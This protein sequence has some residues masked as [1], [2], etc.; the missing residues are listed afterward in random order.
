MSHTYSN[1]RSHI[2]FSTKDRQPLIDD[3]LKPR[4][5]GYINGI[6]SGTGGRVLSMN[7]M[8]DHLHYSGTCRQHFHSQML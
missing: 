6:A 1:L 2:V 7:A 4:L 5:L 8:A 3:E